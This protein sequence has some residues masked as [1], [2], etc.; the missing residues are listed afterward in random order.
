MA[1]NKKD[2]VLDF[3]GGSGTALVSAYKLNRQFIGVEWL[4]DN[5]SLI[6]ERLQETLRQYAKKSNN[7]FISIELHKKTRS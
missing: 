5:F 2:I 6:L 4:E 1:S 7:S 3:Y